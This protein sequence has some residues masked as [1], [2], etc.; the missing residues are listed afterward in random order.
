[1]WIPRLDWGEFGVPLWNSK[2]F[3]LV[4][5]IVTHAVTRKD[6]ESVV[7]RNSRHS[8]ILPW[9]SCLCKTIERRNSLNTE[10][11]RSCGNRRISFNP[12]WEKKNRMAL[13][14]QVL[15]FYLI[16][17]S[18]RTHAFCWVTRPIQIKLSS[19]IEKRLKKMNERN[20]FWGFSPLTHETILV[21]GKKR[22]QFY[23]MMKWSLVV[24][25]SAGVI[26]L[27]LVPR[28]SRALSRA[29]GWTLI[30]ILSF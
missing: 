7:L 16:C 24:R 28:T 19:Q 22:S 27:S 21:L 10:L 11:V 3:F 5:L 9:F 4:T 17:I 18:S 13:V 15:G 6:L 30:L 29:S 1:L 12:R 8:P 2:Q 26:F 25:Q 14:I 23:E 20:A